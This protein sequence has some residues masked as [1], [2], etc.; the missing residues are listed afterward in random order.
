M[1]LNIMNSANY[2]VKF[3]MNS[4]W[5]MSQWTGSIASQLNSEMEQ[6]SHRFN[7]IFDHL[8]YKSHILIYDYHLFIFMKDD[9]P[10]LVYNEQTLRTR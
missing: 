9:A 7:A 8:R 2:L 4:I 1:N 3:R 6:A 5:S 10:L